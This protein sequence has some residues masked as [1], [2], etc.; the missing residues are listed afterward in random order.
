VA[1]EAA[2]D[3]FRDNIKNLSING[4]TPDI[5]GGEISFRI[6]TE[7][8]ASSSF[9]SMNVLDINTSVQEVAIQSP[10]AQQQAAPSQSFEKQQIENIQNQVTETQASSLEP[11]QS[12]PN[13]PQEIK[14]AD[15]IKVGVEGSDNEEN[16]RQRAWSN[17]E[18]NQPIE[19]KVG[20]GFYGASQTHGPSLSVRGAGG[21]EA[22][23]AG[24]QQQPPAMV[25]DT[26]TGENVPVPQG[27]IDQ[28]KGLMDVAPDINDLMANS[29]KSKDYVSANDPFAQYV[30]FTICFNGNAVKFLIPAFGPFPA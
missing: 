30:L 4:V 29:E 1:K 5:S 15:S 10:S 7:P 14:V 2:N 3:V 27:A 18:G 23:E 6:P 28:I 21:G 9:A 22:G 13:V 16:L 8:S 24:Q 20:T 26:T 19:S 25:L 17:Y 12:D 11:P